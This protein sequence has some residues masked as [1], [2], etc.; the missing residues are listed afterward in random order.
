MSKN[1]KRVQRQAQRRARQEVRQRRRAFRKANRRKYTAGGAKPDY[2]DLDGDG[3]KTEPMKSAAKKKMMG[4]DYMQESNEIKFGGPTKKQRGGESTADPRRAPDYRTSANSGRGKSA[5]E[6]KQNTPQGTGGG[7][8]SRMDSIAAGG[9]KSIGA[10]KVKAKSNVSKKLSELSKAP[11][12]RTGDDRSFSQAFSDARKAGKTTFTWRG[13]KYGTKTKEEASRMKPMSTINKKSA[14]A[15]GIETSKDLKTAPPLKS[16][17]NASKSESKTKSTRADRIKARGEKKAGKITARAN[18]KAAKS[19]RRSN[20]KTAKAE[21]KKMIRAAKGKPEKKF[22]GGL[23]GAVRG[24]RKNKGKGLGARM[25][26]AAAGV[27]G[28]SVLGR[29]AGAI[30]GFRGAKG[31]GLKGRIKGAAS[32]AL[33]GSGDEIQAG[34]ERVGRGAKRAVRRAGRFAGR[35]AKKGIGMAKDAASVALGGQDELQYGGP[36][37]RKKK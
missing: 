14:K 30:K 13:K 23:V 26:G 21:A 18:K 27:A 19:T 16:T 20:I 28:G 35:M 4:G 11:S 29:A 7:A 6:K 33:R 15:I 10:K 8:K 24:F 37:N 5:R 12:K 22:I 1:P 2:L 17:A 31:Q 34:A 32:G 25:R 3:N 9:T 36:T